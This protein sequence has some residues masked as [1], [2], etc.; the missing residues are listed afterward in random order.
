MR[1]VG[2]CESIPRHWGVDGWLIVGRADGY[3]RRGCWRRR[4]RTSGRSGRRRRW[5]KERYPCC[6]R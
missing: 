4:G 6:T 1:N 2:G 5:G 3:W